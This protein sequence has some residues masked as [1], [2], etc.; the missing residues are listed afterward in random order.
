MEV[1]EPPPHGARGAASGAL[2]PGDP[3]LDLGEEIG[4]YR[5]RW[6][7]IEQGI[8]GK[9]VVQAAA[10][11]RAPGQFAAELL[12]LLRREAPGL[13]CIKPVIAFRD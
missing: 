2:L 3:G 13:H 8:E 5:C 4:G 12:R 10:F 9:L 11:R 7:G 6:Q 1:P